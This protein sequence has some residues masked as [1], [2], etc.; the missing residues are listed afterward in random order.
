[1]GFE[2]RVLAVDIIGRGGR[3]R[4]AMGVG[5]DFDHGGLIAIRQGGGAGPGRGSA[6]DR[7]ACPSRLGRGPPLRLAGCV[8]QSP[9]LFFVLLARDGR[10]PQHAI[11]R[12]GAGQGR[13]GGDSGMLLRDLQGMRGGRPDM[14]RPCVQQRAA[15]LLALSPDSFLLLSDA[16]KFRDE[17]GANIRL[18]YAG[19]LSASAFR[20]APRRRRE[21]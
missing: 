20:P 12:H 11:G 15:A 4:S 8:R 10:S 5:D 16:R 1:M 6:P 2:N 13:H 18:H 3:A 7:D 17:K 9:A 21:P 19:S 14:A